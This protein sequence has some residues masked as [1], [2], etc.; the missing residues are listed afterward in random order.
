MNTTLLSDAN[1]LSLPPLLNIHV[2]AAITEWVEGTAVKLAEDNTAVVEFPACE[3]GLAGSAIHYCW[4]TDPC[5]FKKCPIYSG[6][7]PSPPFVMNVE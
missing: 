3:T 4:R 7:L 2:G 1:P 6:D 5:S